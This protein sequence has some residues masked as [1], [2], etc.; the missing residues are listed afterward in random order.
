MPYALFPSAL[1]PHTCKPA[2]LSLP[3]RDMYLDL[4]PYV[5]HVPHVVKEKAPAT[6]AYNLFR[7]LGMR[8]LV[9]V[10]SRVQQCGQRA[11]VSSCPHALSACLSVCVCVCPWVAHMHQVDDC[12][13]VVGVITR[14]DLTG[15]R[16]SHVARKV[17]SGRSAGVRASFRQSFRFLI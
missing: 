5:N 17:R 14:A 12:H 7:T 16:I 10:R 4:R 13:D 8:H 6:Q 2:L 9:V 15:H 11:R 3:L 1:C